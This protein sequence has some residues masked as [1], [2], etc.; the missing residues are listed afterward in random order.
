[1]AY[2]FYL[3]VEKPMVPEQDFHFANETLEVDYSRLHPAPLIVDDEHRSK[4]GAAAK[5]WVEDDRTWESVIQ[6]SLTAYERV[7]QATE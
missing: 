6:G 2:T 4:L 5:A 1:M 7:L 3:T